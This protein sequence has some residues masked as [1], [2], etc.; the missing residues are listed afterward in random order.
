MARKP[1]E[2]KV[3]VEDESIFVYDVKMRAVWAVKGSKPFILTTGSHRRTVWFGAL[4][5]D[6]TQLFRQYK[7]A[8][9]DAFLNYLNHLRRKYPRM[10]LFLDK[11]TYH[12]KEERV[13]AYLKK[14]RKTIKTRWFPTGSPESNPVEECW[15][16]GKDFVLGSKL[17]ESFEELKTQTRKYYRTKRFKLNLYEYLCH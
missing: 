13:K 6:G 14:H 16:Q 12:K 15:H 17:P 4:A 3:V 11:A 2:W 1:K 5:E 9:S 8:D 10:I 7:N